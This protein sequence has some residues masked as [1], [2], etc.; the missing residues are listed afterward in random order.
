M[1]SVSDSLEMPSMRFR[2]RVIAIMFDTFEILPA[3][4]EE[5][6]SIDA[7]C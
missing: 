7:A 3:T 2:V 4:V 1:D 5:A 6:M